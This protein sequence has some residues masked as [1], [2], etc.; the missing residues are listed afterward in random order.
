MD[1]SKLPKLS[2]TPKPPDNSA[3]PPP[4]PEQPPSPRPVEYAGEMPPSVGAEAWISIAIGLLVLLMTS[5]FF[6]GAAGST[7]ANAQGQSLRYVETIFFTHDLGLV[8][9]GFALIIDGVLLFVA[10][11][12]AVTLGLVIAVV[13]ALANV[14]TIV[15]SSQLS[16]GFQIMPALAFVIAVYIAIH[17]WKVLQLLKGRR[18]APMT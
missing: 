16:M 4:P 10:R 12:W 7:F 14:Y 6:T 1:M 11:S 13:A 17:Q 9:F 3:P 8:I 15:R 18:Q 2:E 5:R